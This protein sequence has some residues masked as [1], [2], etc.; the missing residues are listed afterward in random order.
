M[1]ET[2]ILLGFYIDRKDAEEALRML[3]R[4][5][6]NRTALISKSVDGTI[7]RN[8]ISPRFWIARG[9]CCGL[10]IGIPVA[11]LI[12]VTAA[13]FS[14]LTFSITLVIAA[15]AGALAA[16]IAVHV[17]HLC[18]DKELV[19][20]HAGWLVAGETVIIVQARLAS[21]EQALTQLR[22]AGV[23]QPSI[24][25]FHL[26]GEAEPVPEPEKTESMTSSQ[27]ADQARLLAGYQRVQAFVG[28]KPPL[29]D[30]VGFCQTDRTVPP[31]A[32]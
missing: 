8:A 22:G 5:R 6:F 10:A 14:L 17:F 19:K 30:Q 13:M 16:W 27:L 28:H 32:R 4:R 9:A 25:A 21:L 26:N 23:A 29:L 3:R 31:G 20:M 7:R 15:A 24:F 1:S 11:L 12:L 2:G 18:V